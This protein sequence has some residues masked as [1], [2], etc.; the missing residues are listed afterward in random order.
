[1]AMT[2]A[3]QESI[4][5]QGEVEDLVFEREKE[6]KELVRKGVSLSRKT[7]AKTIARWRR[8]R[9]YEAFATWKERTRKFDKAK[10]SIGHTVFARLYHRS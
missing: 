2:D 9:C 8:G 5:A 1:M 3:T 10:S 4:D 7:L 6:T